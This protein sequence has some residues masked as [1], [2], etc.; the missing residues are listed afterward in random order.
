[1]ANL[2]S[3]IVPPTILR[4]LVIK[5]WKRS[6]E[7]KREEELVT[8]SDPYL[9]PGRVNENPE[10][11]DDTVEDIEKNIQ[12]ARLDIIQRARIDIRRALAKIRIGTYGICDTCKKPIDISRL[13]AFPQATRCV[14]CSRKEEDLAK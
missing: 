1:M 4:E 2:K 14:D 10:M 8:Q 13:R 12:Q 9:Q 5:L 7:L 6:K 3:M 11:V